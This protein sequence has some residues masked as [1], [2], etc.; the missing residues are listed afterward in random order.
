YTELLSWLFIQRKDFNSAF[1]QTRALDKRLKEGGRRLVEL[2]RVATD[3]HQFEM[4]EKIYQSVLN[5]GKDALYYIPAQR[6]MLDLKYMKVTQTGNYT[7]NDVQAL[8]QSY[9][10]FI[11]LYGMNRVE[12][13]DVVLRLAEIKALYANQVPKAIELLD[14]FSEARIERSMLAKAKLALGD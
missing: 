13:G 9:Q 10:D 2:A 1:I 8:I 11:N 7:E 14:K 4:A 5:E 6:G 12:S 3:Y